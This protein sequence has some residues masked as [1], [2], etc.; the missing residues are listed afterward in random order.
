[1]VIAGCFLVFYGGLRI[2]TEVFRQ[3]DEGVELFMGLSRGQ[4]LSVVQVIAGLVLVF[5]CAKGRGRPVGGLT[6][7]PA[8]A[9]S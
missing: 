6:G 5:I 2:L 4:Q 9:V 3:P 1:G 8:G 7:T